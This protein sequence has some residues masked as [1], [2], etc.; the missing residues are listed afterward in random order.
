MN[1]SYRPQRG[2]VTFELA[3]GLL[4]ACVVAAL[5]G[6][7][8]NLIALQARCSDSAS[9]IVR[10]LAR[11]DT[12]AAQQAEQRVPPAARVDVTENPDEIVV[13]VSVSARWGVF[14]PIEVRGR[15]S[16]PT[17]GR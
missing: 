4:A 5:L 2:M 7:G 13:A 6:W 14:G 17:K 1:S 8:I 11:G 10:Q 16:A 3:I 12:Q 9:Q 15:A